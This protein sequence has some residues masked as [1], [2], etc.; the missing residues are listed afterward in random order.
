MYKIADATQTVGPTVSS[1]PEIPH[2]LDRL[3]NAVEALFNELDKLSSRLLPVMAPSPPSAN[4][5]NP[6]KQTLTPVGGT[7]RRQT[8]EIY[9]AVDRLRNIVEQTQL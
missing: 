8:D 7:I 3:G 6:A 9:A 4:E 1:V 2:E 5:K